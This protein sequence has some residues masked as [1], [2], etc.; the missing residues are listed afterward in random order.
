MQLR[1]TEGVCQAREVWSAR[2]PDLRLLLYLCLV[3]CCQS[4]DIAEEVLVDL[5]SMSAIGLRLTADDL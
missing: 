1:R 2:F 5:P 4:Y 3:S